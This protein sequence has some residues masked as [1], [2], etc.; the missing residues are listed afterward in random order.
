MVT[1]PR[2][3]IIAELAAAAPAAAAG[4]SPVIPAGAVTAVTP[5]PNRLV[6]N[7]TAAA[8]AAREAFAKSLRLNFLSIHILPLSAAGSQRRPDR[9]FATLA[10]VWP[11]PARPRRAKLWRRQVPECVLILPAGPR[12][13]K[14]VVLKLSQHSSIFRRS[15]QLTDDTNVGYGTIYDEYVVEAKA[16]QS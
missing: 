10:L 14:P 2:G 6:G 16:D 1:R 8:P 12:R 4:V 15:G 5:L 7:A 9:T 13:I 3:V 11:C